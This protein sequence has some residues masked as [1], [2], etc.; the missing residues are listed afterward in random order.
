MISAYGRLCSAHLKAISGLLEEFRLTIR[1]DK[2]Q[3][4]RL[5]VGLDKANHRVPIALLIRVQCQG[6]WERPIQCCIR[7]MHKTFSPFDDQLVILSLSNEFNFIWTRQD[8]SRCSKDWPSLA[9]KL[10]HR[11]R[12]DERFLFAHILETKYHQISTEVPSM[13]LL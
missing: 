11:R 3:D 9:W 10:D 4:R 5:W 13:I 7:A 2:D 1:G 6:K 12:P 8:G